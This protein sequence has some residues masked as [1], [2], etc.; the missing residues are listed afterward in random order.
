MAEF[1]GGFAAG[2]GPNI[3]RHWTVLE[4]GTRDWIT[5]S[6]AELG[7]RLKAARPDVLVVQSNDHWVNFFLDAM[8]AFCVGIGDE[9]DGPPEP[10]MK[11]VFPHRTWPG[12]EALG[13]HILDCALDAGFDPAYGQRLKLDHGV[14]VPLWRLA[15][16]PDVPVVPLFVNLMEPPFP[17]PARCAA[18]GRMIRKAID[19]FPGDVRVA[20]LG[21]GGLSH[22]IGEV[23]MGWIDEDF[24][25]ACLELFRGTSDEEFAAELERMLETSGNGSAELRNWLTVHAACGGEGFDLVAYEAVPEILI[26]CGL[27]EWK[28]AA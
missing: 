5:E 12:H 7:R 26:G 22:S 27:A 1:V 20:L 19:G 23:R 21:T 17:K 4:P 28:L 2:H 10:F 6:Y 18:W 9:H 13:R 16:D 8:P 14:C 25:T 3:A 15:V 11:A 24:D